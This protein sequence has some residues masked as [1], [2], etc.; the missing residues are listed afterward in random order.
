MNEL[1][2]IYYGTLLVSLA[3]MALGAWATGWNKGHWAFYAALT[4]IVL[5]AIAFFIGYDMASHAGLTWMVAA[6]ASF[7]LAGGLLFGLTG[8][9]LVRRLRAR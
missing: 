3:A 1:A 8:A 2:L 4:L 7:F 6:F 9:W 5:G